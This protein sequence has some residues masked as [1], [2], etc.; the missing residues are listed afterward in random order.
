ME[1]L[2]SII[3]PKIAQKIYPKIATRYYKF[4][5]K[6]TK[7]SPII[8]AKLASGEISPDQFLK[9]PKPSS[10]ELIR[11]TIAQR[12]IDGGV[13]DDMATRIEESAYAFSQTMINPKQYYIRH[14]GMI[15]INLQV[16]QYYENTIL[17]QLRDRCITPEQLGSLTADDI[18][19]A[20]SEHERTIINLRS[21]QKIQPNV[22]RFYRCPNC[23]VRECTYHTQQTRSLD[24][25]M[26]I[27]CHCIKCNHRFRV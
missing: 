3:E 12:L 8:I 13:L 1:H 19:P 25:A 2:S 17:D 7:S 24:E 10:R 6:I 4:V 11:D 5:A 22:S 23:G 18:C 16:N 9:I 15:M 21:Q 20:A 26:T 14:C 27:F